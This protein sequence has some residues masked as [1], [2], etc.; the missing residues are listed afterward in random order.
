MGQPPIPP[1]PASTDLTGKTVI[2]TGGNAGLGL[3]AA[4]QFLTLKAARVIIAVRS[5]AKGKEAVAELKADATVKKV[6]P[7]AVVETF[8][9][10]LDDFQSGVDFVN[11][12]KAEVPELDILL[13]NGGTNVL[14]YYKSASGHERVM[15]V[16]VYT[17]FLISLGLLPLLISTA[18]RR[19]A[20][21]HLSFVGSSMQNAHSLT[22]KP[23]A[24]NESII[25]HFDDQK[26]YN[27]MTRYQDTKFMVNVLV[28]GLAKSV[29]G[30]N[31]KVI[32]NHMCPGLVMTGFDKDLPI[33][34]KPLM[35]IY[36][37]TS[38]RP[39]SEGARTLI[40]AAAVK[41]PESHGKFMANNTI[42]S[43]E[44]P[45]L[46]EAAGKSFQEKAWKE[47]VTECSKYLPEISEYA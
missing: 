13:N 30:E 19:G 38:A 17:H 3:E 7:N 45:F 37:K 11:K 36:R 20:P 2:V 42:A 41:G 34:L 24:P 25:Q 33:W 1:T 10:D 27:P 18:E 15:Q 21:T 22:K 26:T 12:V 35:Y 32:V 6:N 31:P 29:G 43:G 40:D 47:L 5:P 14:K 4:R 44:I 16:N 9:L 8:R 46:D 28:R 39:V 23:L